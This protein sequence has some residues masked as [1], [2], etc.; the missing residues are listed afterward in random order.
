MQVGI[1]LTFRGNCRK[2][3]EFYKNVFGGE[4]DTVMTWADS[5]MK[6]QTPPAMADKIMHMNLPIKGGLGILDFSL[7]GSDRNEEM[8]SNSK[9]FNIGTNTQ[10]CL[11]PSSHEEADKLFE[12]LSVNG[13]VET[14]LGDQF[15]G[16][17]HG[18]LTDEF[19]IRWMFDIASKKESEKEQVKSDMEGAISKICLAANT[20]KKASE[21][22]AKLM[23]EP[24]VKKAKH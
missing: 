6:D 24:P 13:Q 22:L 10:I 11:S 9:P 12:A 7:M 14:P 23:E 3:F 16:S 17:Y 20:A 21:R 19:G 8:C 5:P 2:A 18:A 15:W 1:Y 4:F